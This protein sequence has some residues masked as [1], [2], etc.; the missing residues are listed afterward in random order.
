MK[1]KVSYYRVFVFSIFKQILAT[2]NENSPVWPNEKNKK[3]EVFYNKINM[4]NQSIKN[5]RIDIRV[6]PEEKEIF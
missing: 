1:N 5:D 6:T 3:F 2:L 4:E